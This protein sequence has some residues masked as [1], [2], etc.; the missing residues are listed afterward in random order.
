MILEKMWSYLWKLE[1]GFW[2][3]GWIS[4]V[5]PIGPN[6]VSRPQAQSQDIFWD[7]MILLDL[8]HDSWENEVL[9]VKIG[10]RILDLW[11]DKG[12]L[13]KNFCRA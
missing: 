4:L 8:P 3:Y 10:A 2:T 9:F 5:S 6:V 12:A 11:L 7:F 1:P 13:T